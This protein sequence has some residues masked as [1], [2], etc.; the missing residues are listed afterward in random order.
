MC[1]AGESCAAKVPKIEQYHHTVRLILRNVNES[2]QPP[3]P[4]HSRGEHLGRVQVEELLAVEVKD[5]AAEL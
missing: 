4:Q 3:A 2:L 5:E 1:F